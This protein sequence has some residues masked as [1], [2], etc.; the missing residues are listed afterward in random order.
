[1]PAEYGAGRCEVSRGQPEGGLRR[2]T[3]TLKANDGS[4][5]VKFTGHAI[6]FQQMLARIEREKNL[7]GWRIT[8]LREVR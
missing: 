7:D 4:C 8:E 3:F 2:Y 6:N 1:M 5:T